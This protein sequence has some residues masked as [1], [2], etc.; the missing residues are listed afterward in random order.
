MKFIVEINCDNAAFVNSPEVEVSYIL[1]NI[2]K[3]V[4]NGEVDSAVR[5]TN[6]NT[7]GKF[8]FTF[9]PGE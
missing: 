1:E 7:V 8:E 6:G 5:D 3:R 4:E 2:A 9:E